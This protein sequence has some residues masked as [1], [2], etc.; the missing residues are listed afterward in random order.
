MTNQHT[1]LSVGRSG[2]RYTMPIPPLS[3]LQLVRFHSSYEALGED[4]C[5]PWLKGR[6]KKD[7][8]RFAFRDTEFQATRIAYKLATGTDPGPLFVCHSCDNPCCVNPKHLWLGTNT[9]NIRDCVSKHRMVNQNKTSCPQG[10]P[11]DAQNTRMSKRG[12]DCKACDNARR[13]ARYR[14]H[15]LALSSTISEET[16]R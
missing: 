10:H 5:W 15:K 4:D 12:R 6:N 11:Y 1:S 13:R 16:G 2:G 9:D 8:G 14:R 7:Y 3:D